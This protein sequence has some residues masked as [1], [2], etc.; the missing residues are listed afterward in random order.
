MIPLLYK[1]QP[2]TEPWPFEDLPPVDRQ[3]VGGVGPMADWSERGYTILRDYMPHY[4]LDAYA[5]RWQREATSPETGF[6]PTDGVTAYR[7]RP[8]LAQVVCYQ[9][10]AATLHWLMGEPCGVH[11]TLT[12]WRS[13][14][15]NWHQDGYLNPDTN[16][17]H[18]VAAWIAVDDIDPDAGPFELVPGSHRLFEPIRQDRMLRALNLPPSNPDWPR[19]SERIL[20]PLFEQLIDRMDLRVE[21][22]HA[23][24]GDVLL[25]HPRLLHRG[26]KPNNPDLERRA[27]IAHYSGIYHRPDMPAA[28]QH[29]AGGWEFPL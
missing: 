15:R 28:R 8:A 6:M 29:Q 14:Q 24:K 2:L 23:K 10:L 7:K 26:T 21:R 3:R 19:E 17:D 1:N 22:F 16:C 25:W 5:E 11:L 9:P 27:L 4:L 20:T 13:T 12:G 18:Y